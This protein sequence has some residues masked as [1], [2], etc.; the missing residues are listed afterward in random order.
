MKKSSLIAALLALG[1]VAVPAMAQQQS[2]WMVRA[3]PACKM[4]QV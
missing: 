2:P 1:A 3:Y 4:G